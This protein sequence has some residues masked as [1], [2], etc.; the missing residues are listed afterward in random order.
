MRR[1]RKRKKRKGE[2]GCVR[3]RGKGTAKGVRAKSENVEG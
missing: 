2:K 3:K 1:E